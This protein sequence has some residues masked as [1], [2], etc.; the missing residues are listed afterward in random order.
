MQGGPAWVGWSSLACLIFGLFLL[1]FFRDPPR[2]PKAPLK[3]ADVLSP[4]DGRVVR[5]EVVCDAAY[6]G[7]RAFCVAIFMNVFDN[8]VNRAPVSGQVVSRRYFPGKFLAA[9][10]EKS[11][12]V[13]EQMHVELKKG[14]NTIVVKQIAGLLARR[15]VC[16]VEEGRAVE[17]GERIGC[18]LLGS[19]VDLLLP[20]S[21][22]AGIRVGD[23]VSAGVHVLGE[24]P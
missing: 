16:W 12:L 17:R 8:H 1:N 2:R 19:R 20:L 3:E 21:F 11:A 14:E 5:C 18:I 13:N 4:A 9:F 23:R 10:S 7:G 24:L 22:K 15:V 6:P